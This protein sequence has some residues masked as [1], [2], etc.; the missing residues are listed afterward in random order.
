MAAPKFP[1]P[2]H[3]KGLR[4]F[5]RYKLEEFKRALLG[6]PPIP[7]DPDKPIE[8]ATAATVRSEFG[9]SHSTLDR[10]VAASEAA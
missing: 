2:V 4:L 3:M 1:K 5:D 8:L 7:R 6:L 9:I 10:H